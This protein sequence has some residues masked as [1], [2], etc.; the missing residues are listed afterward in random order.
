MSDVDE[1]S[2][3]IDTEFA[4]ANNRIKEF[5]AEQVQAY[6]GRQQRMEQLHHA[7]SQLR[8]VWRPRLESLVKKFGDKVQVTPEVRPS[9]REATFA[10][11]SS[12]AHIDLRFT[13]ST[14]ADVRKVILSYDLDIL[15]ILMRFESHAETE[16][17]IDAVDLV[18]AGKWIDD[19]IID[20]VK[21]YL[22]LHE[23]SHY[24]KGAM[25]QD[26]IAGVEF[27][28]FAAAAKLEK[29]GKTYYF[30]GE[31]TRKTFEQQSK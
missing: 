25:V 24:L 12:L 15:P 6:E 23:N 27:P 31:E 10:F 29:D 14:D 3:R 18:A 11:Q 17:P 16:F 5:Q 13:A 21:T 7:F 20:F 22:S 1:L 30:I 8:E 28:K 9:M 26:P 4:A 2:R 19:R